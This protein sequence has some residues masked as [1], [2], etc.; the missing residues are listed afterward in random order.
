MRHVLSLLVLLLPACA[1]CDSLPH[2]EA[3]GAD[4][5]SVRS[6]AQGA[7]VQINKK[8]A[9]A[10]HRTFDP[11]EP[12]SDMP[13]LG[14]NEAAVTHSAYGIGAQVQVVVLNENKSAGQVVSE[15]RIEAVK[16]DTTLAITLWLPK[17]ASKPLIAHEEGHR[18][19]SEMFYEDAESIARGVSQP[20]VGRTIRATARSAE[21]ARE[22][23]M[24]RAIAEING[25]YMS[26]TQ[27]PS[28]RVN[29]LFDR[30]TDHGRNTRVT[31]DA[32]IERALEQYR[33]EKR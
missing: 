10:G 4:Q 19:I 27:I 25:A 32:A 9:Q 21:A 12:P 11:K 20:Y 18:R 13:P 6:P 16:V 30:I 5:G 17:N 24:T 22:A 7:G 33:K 8:P 29:E 26:R 3:D 14:P 31:V 28:S 23:A 2:A 15:M 1:G